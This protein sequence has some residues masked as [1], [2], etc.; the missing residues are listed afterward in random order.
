MTHKTYYVIS[1]VTIHSYP[2]LKEKFDRIYDESFK[3]F[4]I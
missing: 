2:F 3:S 4:E 1:N